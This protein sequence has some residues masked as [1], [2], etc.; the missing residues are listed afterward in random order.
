MIMESRLNQQDVKPCGS[1]HAVISNATRQIASSPS[2]W[3]NQSAEHIGGGSGE[4]SVQSKQG[5]RRGAGC[6]AKGDGVAL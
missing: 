2:V 3:L 4:M 5:M 6:T 1:F